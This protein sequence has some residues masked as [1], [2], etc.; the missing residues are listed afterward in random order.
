MIFR[1]RDYG[2]ALCI[3]EGRLCD[4]VGREMLSPPAAGNATSF[5]PLSQVSTREVSH[6]ATA[7]FE[8]LSL[9]YQSLAVG[10]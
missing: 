7:L 10:R 8:G 3:L 5:L 4:T 6:S 2:T 9:I 1:T